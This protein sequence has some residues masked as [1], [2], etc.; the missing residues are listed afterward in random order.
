MIRARFWDAMSVTKL[1][2]NG[3]WVRL[4][5]DEHLQLGDELHAYGDSSFFRGGVEELG[6]EI[7]VSPE[8]DMSADY[9]HVVIARRGAV[10]KT[11]AELNLAR[12]HG[13]VVTEVRRDGVRLP[14]SSHLRL[15]RSDVLSVAGPKP[16]LR[17]MQEVLGPVESGI[18]ETDM[19]TFAFGIALGALIGVFAINVGGVPIGLGMALSLIHISEPTRPY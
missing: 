2:R 8:I 9:T 12:N 10:G 16:G 18:A 4:G 7:P 5:D 19:A 15:Q 11:I 6:E 3:E 13:L 14:L 1:L 17:E